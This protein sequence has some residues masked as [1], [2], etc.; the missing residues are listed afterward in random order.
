ML[1]CSNVVDAQ[2]KRKSHRKRLSAI[3]AI[4]VINT[5]EFGPNPFVWGSPMSVQRSVT[6]G[7]ELREFVRGSVIAHHDQNLKRRCNGVGI[8]PV[9]RLVTC[10][11]PRCVLSLR[12]LVLI[13]CLLF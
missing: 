6:L 9:N 10:H 4:K 2:H 12:S 11:Y 8:G 13:D 7:V 5:I 1:T 3:V